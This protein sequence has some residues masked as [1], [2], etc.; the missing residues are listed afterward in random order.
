MNQVTILHLLIYLLYVHSQVEE[1]KKYLYSYKRNLTYSAMY[2]LYVKKN[3]YFQS[4]CTKPLSTG[5][6]ALLTEQL[7][8]RPQ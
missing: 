4:K 3:F 2:M 8:H 5:F 6:L 1:N 7:A